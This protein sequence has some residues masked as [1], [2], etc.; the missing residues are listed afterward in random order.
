MNREKYR[1]NIGCVV[2]TII[3]EYQA[4]VWEGIV[5]GAKEKDVNLFTFA[6][7]VT[8][9]SHF[10]DINADHVYNLANPQSVDGLIVLSATLGSYASG[11]FYKKYLPLPMVSVGLEIENIPSVLIDNKGGMKQALSHLIEDHGYKD[12]AFI[13]GPAYNP[14]AE[15]RYQ[16]YLETLAEH[17]IPIKEE[18]IV[19]GNFLRPSGQEAVGVLLDERKVKFNALVAAD[20]N[21][22]LG[23]MDELKERGIRVPQEVAIVGFDDLEETKLVQPPLTAVRQPLLNIGRKALDM[24]LD[25]IEGK[26]VPEKIILPTELIIRQS[27]GCKS[28]LVLKAGEKVDLGKKSP[29]VLPAP[30]ILHRIAESTEENPDLYPLL[31]GILSSFLASLKEESSDKFLENLE[32]Y[33]LATEK[34]TYPT[35]MWHKIIIS[36]RQEI[37]PHIEERE[38]PFA[39][40]LFHQA[41][42]LIAEIKE[43]RERYKGLKTLNE[44]VKISNISQRIISTFDFEKLSQVLTKEL[45]K[46]KI[47]G[48][49][50]AL[51]QENEN[52]PPARLILA[53]SENPI[54]AKD[55]GTWFSPRQLLPGDLAHPPYR[56]DFLIQSLHFED[57]V[58]GYIVFELD[59]KDGFMYELLRGQIS[60]ALYGAILFN[61]YVD[62]LQQLE[63]QV[64]ELSLLNEIGQAVNS[65]MELDKLWELIY[66]Q[67]SRLI[68]FQS[69]YIVLHNEGEQELRTVFD[70]SKGKRRRDREKPRPFAQGRAEYIIRNKKPLLIR[71]EVEK[72]YDQLKITPS[73]KKA[74]AFAGVPIMTRGKVIGVIAVQHYES[75]DAYDEHTI[76]LLSAIANQAGIAI[77]NARLFEATKKLATIDPLTGVWNRR[78]LEE[79]LQREKDRSERFYHPFSI[80]MVDVD[81]LKI[82]NDTYGHLW[83]DEVIKTVARTI[84]SSCR[85]IDMVGRYGGDEFVVILPETDQKGAVKVSEKILSSIKNKS[86]TTP[87]GAKIPLSVSIGIASYPLDAEDVEKLLSLADAA[88]YRAKL[89]GGGRAVP[90]SE[91]VEETP[92]PFDVLGG[93]LMA[94][95]SKD[96]YTLKHSL[97]VARVACTLGRALGLPEE[98][99]KTLEIAGKL[100]DIGKIGI[101]SSIL[102]KPGPLTP[103]EWEIIKEHPTLGCPIMPHLSQLEVVLQAILHHHE[104][105]DGKGY[106]EGIQGDNIPLLARILASADAYCAMR[107]YHPYRKALTKE[108]AIEEIKR[109]M[110]T[111]LDPELAKKLIELIEKGEI[112]L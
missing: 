42:L 1:L 86:L 25:S 46:L 77:E 107:S 4:R 102:K 57:K 110:G 96:N 15:E 22:A 37:L 92:V 69:L 27:C 19:T 18:L 101:S 97:D 90:I 51:Y 39:E 20:G 43:R 50:L 98:D 44:T 26:H 70:I 78:S 40:N 55:I 89:T 67:T 33:L 93:L 54:E 48:C 111:Q 35:E 66:Q 24:L 65:A 31:D 74:Q 95:N 75:S 36:L 53:Y 82:L 100:H 108:E 38:I 61:K 94:I 109:N 59:S 73:D 21:M 14:E 68:D 52:S 83:G 49:Y 81:N 2:D 112:E 105:Y 9:S 23:A 103:E 28:F 80:L 12:I 104:R 47:P 17:S 41:Q 13:R 7:G 84:Q 8:Y 30:E 45:K 91:E 71:G 87:D 106:P 56:R 58:L 72:I 11:D 85:R 99:I 64:K 60:S 32:Q 6:G 76:E 29:N 63:K 10:F 62:A 88:M 34:D 5:G 16:A 79:A 3:Y